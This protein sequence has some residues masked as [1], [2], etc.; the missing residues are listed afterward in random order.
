MTRGV[1]AAGIAPQ[2]L[3]PMGIV[4][5]AGSPDN[6]LDQATALIAIES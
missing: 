2:P 6:G 3:H 4:P 5:G 1:H